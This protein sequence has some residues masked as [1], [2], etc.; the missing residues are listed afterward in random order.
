MAERSKRPILQIENLQVYYGESH[1][2][3][4]VSLTLESGIISVVGRDRKSVV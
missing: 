2:L 4:G 3:Q 1:A